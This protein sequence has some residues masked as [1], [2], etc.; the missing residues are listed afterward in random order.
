MSTDF[1]ERAETWD[2]DLEHRDRAAVAAALLRDSV[3]TDGTTRLLEY[4]AGTGLLSAALA[5]HVGSVVVTDPSA[6]MR[7]VL[8]RKL[9]DGTFGTGQVLDL[10][11]ARDPVPDLEVDLVVALMSL[12]HVPELAPV[13]T[14]FARLLAP[15]GAVGII[16]LEEEDGSFHSEGFD[17]HHGFAREGLTAQLEA[18]GFTKVA[19]RDGP[20]ID[21]E[22]R[23]YP[24]FLCT[25]RRATS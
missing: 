22:E 8:E 19:F 9:A 17:G 4:G 15:G 5:P 25:A 14:G 24:L 7:G 21:K 11:L 20:V 12:H 1:D 23:A 3:P 13:L 16:D 2:D 10:D 18:A 6:G